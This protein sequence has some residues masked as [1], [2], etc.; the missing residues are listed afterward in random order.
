MLWIKFV[1]ELILM[2]TWAEGD[3][4]G[5]FIDSTNKIV[6]MNEAGECFS[7]FPNIVIQFG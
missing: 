2:Q 7:A 1:I 4:I 6:L 5:I 3:F